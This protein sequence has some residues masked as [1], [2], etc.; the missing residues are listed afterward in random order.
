[1]NSRIAAVVLA[2]GRGRRMARPKALL[3]LDN[4]RSLER[5][6]RVFRQAG[7]V[8]IVVVLAEADAETRRRIDLTRAVTALQPRSDAPQCSSVR[9]GVAN[10]PKGVEAFFLAPVDVPLFE[11]EDVVRLLEAWRGRPRGIEV[12]VP[13]HDGRRG[14]PALLG[15][16][17][18]REFG[19][20]GDDEP[21]HAVLRRDPARVLHVDLPNP[22]LYRDLDGPED[23]EWARAHLAG[24]ATRTAPPPA[25]SE[26]PSPRQ[27]NPDEPTARS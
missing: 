1:M 22:G 11:P 26:R 12:V 6:L 7:V 15:A 19:L 9:I 21:T 8:R 14:H 5:I 16:R 24:G 2:A 27:T 10:L 18:A 4:E 20:L 3:E 17:L 13:A 23:L 25:A